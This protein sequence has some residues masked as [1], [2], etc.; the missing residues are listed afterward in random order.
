[1]VAVKT[2][3]LEAADEVGR[4]RRS[5]SSTSSSLLSQVSLPQQP[6]KQLTDEQLEQRRARV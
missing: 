3:R 5:K 2:A 4:P 1:M 6:R